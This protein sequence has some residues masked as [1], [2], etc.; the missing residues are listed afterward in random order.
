MHTISASDQNRGAADPISA[1]AAV[2]GNA[3]FIGA[4]PCADVRGLQSRRHRK[5]SFAGGTS[6]NERVDATLKRDC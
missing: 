1:L 6:R 4:A 2:V 5:P 3:G